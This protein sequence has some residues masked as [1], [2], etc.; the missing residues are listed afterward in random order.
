MEGHGLIPGWLQN[1]RLQEYQVSQYSKTSKSIRI[2]PK[3]DE[4]DLLEMKNGLDS[5]LVRL[6]LGANRISFTNADY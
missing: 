2:D 4:N 3:G 1:T 5:V 6:V